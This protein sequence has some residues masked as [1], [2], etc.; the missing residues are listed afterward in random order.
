MSITYQ[1]SVRIVSRITLEKNKMTYIYDHSKGTII[2][3]EKP[4]LKDKKTRK[5]GAVPPKTQTYKYNSGGPVKP[6]EETMPERL[7]RLLYIYEDGPKPAHYDNPNIVDSENFKK[8]PKKFNNN[9]P[10]TYPS[11]R[12][13]KQKISTWDLMKQTAR[14]NPA[15]MKEIREIIKRQYKSDPSYLADDELKMIGKYKPKNKVVLPEPP[16][17]IIVPEPIEPPKPEKP[18][19]QIIK[20]GADERLKLEQEQ[21]DKQVGTGGITKILRPE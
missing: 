10:S 16:K 12:D 17:P 8:I 15:E 13:Q 11:N 1:E 20:E 14:G 3:D 9:D 6:R 4:E 7:E 5:P 19:Q 18:L 2:S 21:Y